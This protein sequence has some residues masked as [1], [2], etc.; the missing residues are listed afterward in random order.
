MQV[1]V[2]SVSY[3]HSARAVV[4]R[5]LLFQRDPEWYDV[6]SGDTVRSLMQQVEAREGLLF[7]DVTRVVVETRES[8]AN[9]YS[10]VLVQDYIDENGADGMFWIYVGAETGRMPMFLLRRHAAAA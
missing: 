4:P 7:S 1:P 3:F 10:E 6:Q 9:M 2:Y 8:F 5:R